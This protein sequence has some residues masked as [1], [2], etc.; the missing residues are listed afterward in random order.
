MP[1]I[2][3]RIALMAAALILCAAGR[4]QEPENGRPLEERVLQLER[5]LASLETRFG[6]REAQEPAAPATR[7]PDASASIR[8]DQLERQ[9][10]RLQAA[11]DRLEREIQS[12]LR[13]A[14]RASREAANA[15]LIARDALNRT[16]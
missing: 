14:N 4:A 5:S 15:G 12:A 1:T 11:L 2:T 9:L 3:Q 6:L 10:D 13:A 8:I 7:G 16:R